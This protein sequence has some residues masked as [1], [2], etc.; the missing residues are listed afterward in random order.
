MSRAFVALISAAIVL[1]MHDSLAAQVCAPGASADDR[2]LAQYFVAHK[3]VGTI[4]LLN[5]T[6]Q[7][8]VRFNV[9]RARTR[10][11]PASTFK[12]FNTMVALDDGS[13]PD[14]ETVLKWDGV[15]LTRQC[16]RQSAHQ[17]SS[18]QGQSRAACG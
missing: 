12:I 9:E 4:V 3:V 18:A 16:S 11:L 10:F 2:S 17:F 14:A 6:R 7:T 8:C 5:V 13:I 15:Y 1:G